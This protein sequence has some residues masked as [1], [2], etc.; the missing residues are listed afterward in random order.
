IPARFPDRPIGT[1]FRGVRQPKR[2]RTRAIT[3]VTS[4]RGARVFACPAIASRCRTYKRSLRARPR[5]LRYSLSLHRRRRAAAASPKSVSSP[6]YTTSYLF[7]PICIPSL[8]DP[9][10][11][12]F[13]VPLDLS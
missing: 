4:I 6:A 9:A 12:L 10:L 3:S 5:P 13:R 11:D 2:P 1:I 7:P 8:S